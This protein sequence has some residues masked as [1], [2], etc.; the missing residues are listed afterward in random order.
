MA[1]WQDAMPRLVFV[2]KGV[3]MKKALLLAASVAFIAPQAFAQAKNFEGFSVGAN[4]ASTK[5]TIEDATSSIDGTTASLDLNAQY[6]FALAPQFVLGVGL[7]LGTGN[8]KAGTS[9]TAVDVITKNRYALEFTPGYA[10][11]N[12]LLVYGKVASLSA[13]VEAGTASESVSGVGY[14]LGVRGLVDKNMYWQVGYDANT[15]SEKTSATLG[16]FKGK[17]TVLSLGVGYKF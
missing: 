11:S 4:L 14:G 13:T 12:T 2:T 15:Y 10:V 9:V 1:V 5:T 8:N 7:T 3:F 16:T 6:N 17:S